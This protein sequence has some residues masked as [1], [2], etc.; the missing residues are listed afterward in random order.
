M[1]GNDAMGRLSFS[2]GKRAP[3]AI[4]IHIE[5]SRD[6]ELGRVPQIGGQVLQQ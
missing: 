5:R 4:H 6:I 2:S 1:A 3:H